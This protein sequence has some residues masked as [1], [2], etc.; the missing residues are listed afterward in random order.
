MK[1]DS[2]SLTKLNPNIQGITYNELQNISIPLQV[3]NQI[4]C[5]RWTMNS[6]DCVNQSVRRVMNQSQP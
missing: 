6:M 4:S 5:Q 2:M 1:L 3:F